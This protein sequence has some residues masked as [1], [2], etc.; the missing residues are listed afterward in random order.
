MPEMTDQ[1]AAA[2]VEARG[3]LCPSDGASRRGFRPT[4][5]VTSVDKEIIERL[6]DHFGLGKVDSF[7][8]VGNPSLEL[9]S[10]SMRGP[11]VIEVLERVTPHML[12]GLREDAEYI[13][14]CEY[15]RPSKTYYPAQ[16]EWLTE[17]SG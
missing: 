13:L 6:R 1:C 2:W 16:T 14:K 8:P 17:K 5:S 7:R 3:R 15:T 9:H 12:G 11:A 10:W 4:L